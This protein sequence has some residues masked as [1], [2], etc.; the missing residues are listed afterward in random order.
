M[1]HN[2]IILDRN[3]SRHPGAQ[4]GFSPTLWFMQN[5][6]FF[7][8]ERAFFLFLFIRVSIAGVTEPAVGSSRILWLDSEAE[9]WAGQ[10]HRRK[11]EAVSSCCCSHDCQLAR[12]VT[13]AP[14]LCG[15]KNGRFK[16][17]EFWEIHHFKCPFRF[18]PR[19]GV[20]RCPSSCPDMD[21]REVIFGFKMSY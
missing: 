12:G 5:A 20:L 9:T 19:C 6:L 8:L 10:G 3:P 7:F 1:D 18:V 11:P 14:G 4:L 21:H 16:G 13:W 17:L 2:G 15:N